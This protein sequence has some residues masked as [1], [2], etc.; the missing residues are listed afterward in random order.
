VAAAA[1]KCEPADLLGGL[2][3]GRAAVEQLGA[4]EA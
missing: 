2:L 3:T 1:L 4:E